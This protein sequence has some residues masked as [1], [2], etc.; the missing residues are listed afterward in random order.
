MDETG[1]NEDRECERL[2]PCCQTRNP[3]CIRVVI[4][5]GVL[6][7]GVYQNI[8]IGKQHFESTVPVPEPGLIILYIQRPWPVEI[9]SRTRTNATH[10]D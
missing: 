8:H 10:S 5:D 7:M 3:S 1:Q 4:R 2:W 9:N 6:D